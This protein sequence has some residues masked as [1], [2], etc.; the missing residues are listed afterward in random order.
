MLQRAQTAG[1]VS[2]EQH[3]TGQ[4]TEGSEGDESEEMHRNLPDSPIDAA[5]PYEALIA[6]LQADVKRVE[7]A[8]EKTSRANTE[9]EQ[10]LEQAKRSGSEK[11]QVLQ[12]SLEESWE[13]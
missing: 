4:Q 8:Y 6:S 9:L 1:T 3:R 11:A 12:S 7:A 13:R 2:T 10:K 5:E